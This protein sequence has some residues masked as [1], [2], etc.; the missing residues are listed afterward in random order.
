VAVDPGRQIR[1]RPERNDDHVAI[2][3]V[4]AAAFKSQVEADLVAAVRASPDYVPA[5]ALVAEVDGEVVGHVMVSWTGLQDGEVTHRIQHLAP[6]AVAPEHQRQRI[7]T[8]LVTTVIAAA[9]ECGAPFVVLEGDPRYYSRF[10]FESSVAHGITMNLPGWAPKQAAQILLLNGEPP[11]IRGH[12]VHPPAFAA[13][14][15]H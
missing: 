6:L 12:V 14:V 5:L 8:A 13:F 9:R 4:V 2:A 1:I 15:D 7:G 11:R 3:V 10:G